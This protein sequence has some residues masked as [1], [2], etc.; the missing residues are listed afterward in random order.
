MVLELSRS[1]SALLL[2]RLLMDN[3]VRYF[4]SFYI[5]FQFNLLCCSLADRRDTRCVKIP[6]IPHVLF[7]GNDLEI[8][9]KIVAG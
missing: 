2:K 8:L 7:S 6:P 3:Q 9:Q 1:I 5:H 4:C